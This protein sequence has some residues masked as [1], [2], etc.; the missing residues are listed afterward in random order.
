[1]QQPRHNPRPPDAPRGRHEP[2]A[3][4][5]VIA[6]AAL[7]VV[8][9]GLCWLAVQAGES[10]LTPLAPIATPSVP[11]AQPLLFPTADPLQHV[12]LAAQATYYAPTVTPTATATPT[13]DLT[14]NPAL[15]PHV[16]VYCDTSAAVPG[17]PCTVPSPPT[18]TPTPLADCP[19][20]L[21]QATPYAQCIDRERP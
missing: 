1:M 4:A 16:T 8:S 10:F 7:T 11:A 2:N 6:T 17:Q 5:Q 19:A 15:T 9:L 14:P 21:S 3:T 20:D 12:A 13:P 18:P